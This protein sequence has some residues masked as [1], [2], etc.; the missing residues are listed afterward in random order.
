VA[1]PPPSA[2]PVEVRGVLVRPS[3]VLSTTPRDLN[4]VLQRFEPSSVDD[5][6]DIIIATNILIYYDVFEQL[7]AV[8][9]IAKMLR[10]GGFFLSNDRIFELPGTPVR[11]VGQT[12][13]TYMELPR[14]MGDRIVW[15]QRQ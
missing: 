10:P 9:N 7:L 8:A 1:A 2:G 14:G 13:V 15:Y 12:D 6:F 3:V 5:Q 4:I 11:S